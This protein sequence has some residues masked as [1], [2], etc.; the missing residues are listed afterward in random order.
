MSALFSSY[1]PLKFGNSFYPGVF[2]CVVYCNMFSTLNVRSHQEVV[3]FASFG[4]CTHIDLNTNELLLTLNHSDASVMSD[5]RNYW[6]R[7]LY[8]N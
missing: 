1:K 6:S 2:L 8:N 3:R 7:I 4:L 5:I